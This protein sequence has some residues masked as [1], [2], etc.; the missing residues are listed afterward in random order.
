M[1]DR[2]VGL[3]IHLIFGR[4]GE[5]CK[6]SEGLPLHQL[7]FAHLI[8]PMLKWQS[9]LKLNVFRSWNRILLLVVGAV[10]CSRFF[11]PRHNLGF[12]D[13]AEGFVIL[14]ANPQPAHSCSSKK[15]CGAIKHP[16]TRRFKIGILF[17]LFHPRVLWI[18]ARRLTCSLT[19]LDDSSAEYDTAW[20]N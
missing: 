18:L 8:H 7:S 13:C 14:W 19:Q 3:I 12:L 9:T 6:I 4:P 2:S 15:S 17:N 1:V 16:L 11:L 10:L 5:K 20:R